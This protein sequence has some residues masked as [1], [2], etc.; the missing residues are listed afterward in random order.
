M[1]GN[2]LHGFISLVPG[3]YSIYILPMERLTIDLG[4]LP[5]EG[6]TLAGDLSP[7]IFELPAG[8]V[9]PLGP[10]SYE[11]HVQRFG[12]ELLLQGALRAPFEFKCVRT[13][14][15]FKQ[16]IEIPGAAI[17]LEIDGQGQIDA[18]EAVRE[19]L[20]LNLPAYPRCDEGDDPHPCEIDRRYLAVDKPGD[21]DVESPPALDGDSRWAALD[22][23]EDPEE[24]S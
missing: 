6:K 4:T 12:D 5:E 17:S 21:V 9:Q 19:E 20:L 1:G 10:L 23:L 3:H 13:L 11:L 7:T 8:D 15:L 16:T 2:A 22:T 18:T 24:P 14:A